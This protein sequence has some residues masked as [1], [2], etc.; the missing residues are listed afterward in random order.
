MKTFIFIAMIAAA[1]PVSA[2]GVDMYNVLERFKNVMVKQREVIDLCM[3]HLQLCS[4]QREDCL[5]VANM[6]IDY[7]VCTNPLE[8]G[9]AL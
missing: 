1:I 5:N 9:L 6:L 8:P 4:E 3:G 7:C 2:T